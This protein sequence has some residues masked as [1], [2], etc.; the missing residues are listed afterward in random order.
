LGQ[1]VHPLGFRLVSTQKHRSIAFVKFKNY[2]QLIC[3]DAVIRTI[4]EKKKEWSISEIEIERDS[5]CDKI[6]IKVY[7]AQPAIFVGDLG[8]NLREIYTHLKKF[9]KNEKKIIINTINIKIPDSKANLIGDFIVNL[10]ESRIPFK[11]AIKSAIVRTQI[12]K[13]F[14]IKV[15]VSGRLNGAEMARTE[16]VREGRVPLQTLQANIDYTEKRANTIYGVIG[17]KIWLFNGVL[18]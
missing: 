16:W 15:Q 4:V 10:L 9:I 5:I 17:I 1:K 12:V 6:L 14:G 11:K 13:I 8:I 7:T 3:E 2:P 18:T